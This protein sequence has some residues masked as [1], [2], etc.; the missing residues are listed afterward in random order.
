MVAAYWSSRTAYLPHLSRKELDGRTLLPK[1]GGTLQLELVATARANGLLAYPLKPTFDALFGELSAQHPVIVLMNRSYAWYPLWHYA[2]VTGYDAKNRAMLMHFSTTPNEAIPIETFAAM[3]ERSGRWAV[4][5]L[6]PSEL[7]ETVSEHKFLKA[8]Y[9][10]EKTGRREDAITAYRSALKRWPTSSN[11]RFALANAYYAAHDLKK[12][13][14]QF[15]KLL[16]YDPKHPLALNNL[17]SL[18]CD[19]GKKQEALRVIKKANS[20][21]THVQ[22]I[23][24]ATRKDIAQGCTR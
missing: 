4:V 8:A 24:K 3:W 15:R 5:L 12:A 9:A 6:P 2:P 11:I 17:A 20:P 19:R 18:L 21:D 14:M 23:L 22:T 7:P 13:E 16:T 10:L 1:K